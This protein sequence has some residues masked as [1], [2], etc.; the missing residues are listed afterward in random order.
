MG[1]LN[2]IRIIEIAGLG[3][4]PFCG[5]MLVDHGAEVIR[6]ARPGSADEASTRD[7][8]N[9]SRTSLSIDLKAQGGI[10]VVKRLSRASHGLIEG[11][12]PGVMERL[13]LGPDVLERFPLILVHSRRI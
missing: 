2:G 13:G 7:V 6:I 4:A 1:P 8:L 3:P 5:M 11:F 10:E 12:R 9:R